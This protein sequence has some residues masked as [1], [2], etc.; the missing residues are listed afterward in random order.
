[1]KLK[2]LY[3]FIRPR[4][5]ANFDM[6]LTEDENFVYLKISNKNFKGDFLI[7]NTDD[8]MLLKERAEVQILKHLNGRVYK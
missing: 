7:K 4:L 2:E 8:M 5:N 1:M 3:V 6:V